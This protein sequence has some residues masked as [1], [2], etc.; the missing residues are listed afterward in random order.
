MKV[1]D[2]ISIFLSRGRRRTRQTCPSFCEGESDALPA[3][4][5][6]MGD[7]KL[8]TAFALDFQA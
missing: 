5:R 2:P 3:S 7:T 8:V 1:V 4:K 6:A